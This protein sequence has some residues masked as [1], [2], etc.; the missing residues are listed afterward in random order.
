MLCSLAILALLTLLLPPARAHRL[1][2]HLT[3]PSLRTAEYEQVED[4]LRAGVT[5]AHVPNTRVDELEPFVESLSACKKTGAHN[6]Y[7]S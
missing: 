6:R 7:R 5:L 4:P 1:R 2:L 3:P